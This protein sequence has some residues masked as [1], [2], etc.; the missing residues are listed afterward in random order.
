MRQ[1]DGWPGADLGLTAREGEVLG[2]LAK[3]MDNRA[4]AQALYISEGTV[5]SHVKAIL[6]KLGA[7]DRTQ[8]ASIALRR[9][10]VR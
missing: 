6:R 10:L 8:A 3:G 4:I 1:G 5:K 7:K 9:G 2:Y